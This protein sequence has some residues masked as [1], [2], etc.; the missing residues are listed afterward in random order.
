MKLAEY[1]R[2]IVQLAFAA[3]EPRDVHAHEFAVTLPGHA[4]HPQLG[5]ARVARVTL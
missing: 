1:Q 5:G 3:D 2:A 4:V